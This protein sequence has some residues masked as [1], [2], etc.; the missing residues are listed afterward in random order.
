MLSCTTPGR[1]ICPFPGVFGTVLPTMGEKATNTPPMP[2]YDA[3]CKF[4]QGAVESQTRTIEENTPAIQWMRNMLEEQGYS[5]PETGG[6][7]LHH[8]DGNREPP[9]VTC[10]SRSP[11]CSLGGIPAGKTTTTPYPQERPPPRSTLV[12]RLFRPDPARRV[13]SSIRGSTIRRRR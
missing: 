3:R 1:L 5:A 7:L 9:S 6:R 2:D 11:S 8:G 12:D 10:R 13:G 4:L